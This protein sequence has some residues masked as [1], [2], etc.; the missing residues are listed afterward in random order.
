MKQIGEK[1]RTVVTSSDVAMHAKVSQATVSRVFSNSEKVRPEMAEHVLKVAR[2]LGYRP[3]AIARSLTSRQT[4]MIAVVSVDF[5]NPFYQ[6]LLMKMYNMISGMGKK[7]MLIQSPFEQALDSV[8]NQV[9]EYQVDGIVV[10]SAA[11][12]ANWV[13]DIT[14]TQTPLVIFNKYFDSRNY[15]SV[16]SDNVD[17]GRLVADYL[18]EKK[19][20]SFGFISSERLSQ[21]NDYRHK[22]FVGRLKELGYDRCVIGS[23]DYSYQSGYEALLSMKDSGPLPKAIF[24]VNDLMALGAMDAARGK[25]GLRI[26]EDIA[27][28]GFDN[29]EQADWDAYGLTSVQQPVDEMVSYTENY[30]QNKFSTPET[31]GGYI[32][33]KCRLVERSS[34]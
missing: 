32:L 20:D 4:D 6:T 34:T 12:S 7:M 29:L 30:L 13:N 21:T 2:E 22:G 28:V 27:F 10:F 11:L 23:G 3:N 26:P 18:V 24:C 1:Q 14:N 19:F 15:F 33:L 31:S 9:M 8:L 5:H 17:A 25:L 16:C